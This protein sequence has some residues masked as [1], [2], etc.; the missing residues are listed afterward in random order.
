M[1]QFA[2]ARIGAVLVNINPAYRPFELKYVL[3][4][5][6]SVAL[7]LVEQFKTSDYFA[8]LAEVCPELAAATPGE[9]DAER[10]SPAAV[11]RGAGRRSARRRHHLGRD[12]HARPT[13]STAQQA[14][15]RS[16]RKLEPAAADQHPVH[17]R[18]DRLSQG[19]HA[20]PSQPAAQRLLRR[21]VPG[22]DG[23]RSDLHSGAVLSL[24]R[25]RAG[26]DHGGGLRRG[27]GRSGR[28]LQRRGDARRHREGT[29]HGAL[30]RADDVH[31]P[32]AGSDAA[33]AA[34]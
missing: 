11:G 32:A 24:L 12:A 17:L 23:R 34:I 21:D 30:R 5:S 8:M 27:D 10:L 26:H 3:N 14:R 18:H 20:Q 28:E 31:R 13:R 1:L 19:G 29:G 22:A 15:R 7:F 33:A 2:T 25:L 6:D 4:Q 9:L 16:T